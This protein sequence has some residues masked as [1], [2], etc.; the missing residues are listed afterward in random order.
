MKNVFVFF[1][2]ILF[3]SSSNAQL[4]NTKWK[5]T[6]RINSND[7]N[8]IMDFRKDTVLLYTVTDSSMIE[9]MTYTTDDSSFTLLKIDGQ[10]DCDNVPGK[11][12]FAIKEDSLTMKLLKDDCYDRYNV[13]ENTIWSRVR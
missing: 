3:A 11:Y 2:A 5:T 6:L 12:G 13:I 8:C 10:S 9:R 7:V 1:V 4:T